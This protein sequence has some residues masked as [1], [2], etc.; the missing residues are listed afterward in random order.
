MMKMKKRI[1]PLQPKAYAPCPEKEGAIH[2]MGGSKLVSTLLT[3]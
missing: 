2:V 1:Q 3:P